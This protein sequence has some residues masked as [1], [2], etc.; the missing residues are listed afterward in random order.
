MALAAV[1][2]AVEQVR[3]LVLEC[4]AGRAGGGGGGGADMEA[5]CGVRLS[6]S[7]PRV[8]VGRAMHKAAVKSLVYV[9]VAAVSTE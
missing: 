9:P 1:G 3:Q 6:G 8:A 5:A 7:S 4:G 2:A